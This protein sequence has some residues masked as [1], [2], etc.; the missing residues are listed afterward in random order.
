MRFVFLLPFI[1]SLNLFAIGG[2]PKATS[3]NTNTSANVL[4]PNYSDPNAAFFSTLRGL[5][6]FVLINGSSLGSIAITFPVGA[7]T[8]KTLNSTLN[9]RE[10][11]VPASSA[12]V[13]DAK[14]IPMN[15]YVCVRS[16]SYG[17]SLTSGTIDL[18]VW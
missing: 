15:K 17:S 6:N 18:T 16:K 13:I 5:G 12:L 10:F 7:E 4:G 14:Q 9:G 2:T 1:V 3:L 11:T 8:C